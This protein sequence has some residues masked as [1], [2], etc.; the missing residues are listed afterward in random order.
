MIDEYKNRVYRGVVV[1]TP[2]LVITTNPE[3]LATLLDTCSRDWGEVLYFLSNI[4]KKHGIPFDTAA[5]SEKI[6]ELIGEE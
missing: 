3:E 1:S 4:A 2:F 5:I 6:L